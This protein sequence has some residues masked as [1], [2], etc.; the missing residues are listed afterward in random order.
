MFDRKFSKD[1]NGAAAIE[2]S[3]VA[4]VFIAIM[5]SIFYFG[6][7]AMKM[8]SVHYALVKAGRAIML[9][10]TL[11][12]TEIQTIVTDKVTTLS[13]GTGVTVAVN[14]A[15]IVNGSALTTLTA[16]YPIT[17][18]VPFVGTYTYNYST[19]ITVTTSA[20]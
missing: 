17:F 1:D 13:G 4:P 12:Q 8:H 16:T 3:L 18:E 19:V 5:L 6:S 20:S 9:K 7:T 15:G 11:T 10:P 14:K 2:F